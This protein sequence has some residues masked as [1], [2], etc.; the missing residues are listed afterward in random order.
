MKSKLLIGLIVAFFLVLGAGLTYSYFNSTSVVSV[1]DQKIAKFVFDTQMM[2]NLNL[3][4]IDLVPGQ[5]KEYEFSV[6]NSLEDVKSDVTLVYQLVIMTPHLSPLI[7]E[8]YNSE[9]KLVL[10]C[11]ETYTR[12]LN[13]ELICNSEEFEMSYE[14]NNS[15][16]YKLK[17]TFDGE[18]NDE[19]YSGL[20]DYINIEIKSHQKV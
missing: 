4:L 19:S 3:P 9:D 1:Q 15:Q 13:N 7:I 10:T 18:Y 12:N 16:N 6:A 20:V 14:N 8:L 11:D 5:T 2:D 17:V